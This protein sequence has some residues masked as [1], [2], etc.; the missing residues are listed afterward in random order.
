MNAKRLELLK[1]TFPQ[2][3]RVAVLRDP[4]VTR[5][6]PGHRGRGPRLGSTP[7]NLEVR[8]LDDLERAVAA[9]TQA[10]ADAVNIL[11][12]SFFAANRV[13]IVAAVRQTQLPATYPHRLFV[14][15]GG[16]MSYGPH[17][18]TCSGAPPPMW[19]KSCKGANP[20]DLPVEQPMRFE[21]VINLQTAQALGLTIPPMV[22]FQ[23]DEV[24][25]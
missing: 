23:A 6:S 5:Q 24:I 3:S 18:Q 11:N 14:E 8:S 2:V 13:R 20:A 15:A 1:E 7:A 17:S 16:L 12:S 22:L 19:T 9:A 10:H 4:R 25:H 21:L